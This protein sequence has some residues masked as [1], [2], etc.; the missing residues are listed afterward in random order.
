[1]FGSPQTGIGCSEFAW[2][3]ST[4]QSRSGSPHCLRR[5]SNSKHS[6][7]SRKG[8]RPRGARPTPPVR[9]C[10]CRYLAIPSR[11]GGVRSHASN[12]PSTVLVA[13]EAQALLGRRMARLRSLDWNLAQAR[14][15]GGTHGLHPYPAK[16]IPQIP[17]QLIAELAPRDGSIVLDPFCGSG[18]TL[19]EAQAAGLPAFGIDSHPLATLI[20]RVKTRPPSRAL[21]PIATTL[22]KQARR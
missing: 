11:D 19:V 18:T 13:Q 8:A 9:G 2:Q 20:A 22:V 6:P 4:R 7:C 12:A 3:I 17:R 5:R 1:M 21:F 16:F 14:T 15:Q 10:T